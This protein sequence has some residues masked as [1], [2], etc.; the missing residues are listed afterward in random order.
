[1][2][3]ADGAGDAGYGSAVKAAR[4]RR[5]R[6]VYGLALVCLLL[7][8]PVV[9]A[10][11]DKADRILV[12]K[13]QH[14]M[15]LYRGQRQLAVYHVVFGFNPVG[16]KQQEG[17]GRTPE[18]RYVLD[19]KKANS[20]YYKAIRISY[21]NARDRARARQRGV[22]PGGAIMIHGQPN[23]YAWAQAATQLRNWTWGC[24]ALRNEDMEDVW[25]R[26]DVGTVIEIRP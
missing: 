23:G 7:L 6:G 14:R 13:S 26:V 17:D 9:L 12:E 2:T 10:A 18:G 16:H 11:P 20:D 24:I 15:T 8:A 5:S 3:V 19:Y 1:M 22:D 25:Q 21:P 4:L